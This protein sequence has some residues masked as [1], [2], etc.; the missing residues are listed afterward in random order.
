MWFQRNGERFWKANS[1]EVAELA[2]LPICWEL[3]AGRS[4]SRKKF[5][6]FSR[7]FLT[8][9]FL[10]V[11]FCETVRFQKENQLQQSW[12]ARMRKN[13]ENI[14]FHRANF[15]SMGKCPFAAVISFFPAQL[16][17]TLTAAKSASLRFRPWPKTACDKLTS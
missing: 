3:G 1:A 2:Q 6:N 7:E 5:D 17:P 9:G 12:S 16:E 8:S 11:E 13:K 14:S 10:S 4:R 15:W